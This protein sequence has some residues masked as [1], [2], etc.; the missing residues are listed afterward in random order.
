[1]DKY[2]SYTDFLKAVGQQPDSN[3]AEKLLNEIYLDLFLNRLQRMHRIEQL[4]ALIDK[5]LDQKNEQKFINYTMELK[6][7]LKST[8]A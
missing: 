2:Y 5:S 8:T 4:K 7:L 6:E 1:M 3:Q